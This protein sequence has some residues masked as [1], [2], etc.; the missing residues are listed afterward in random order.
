VLRAVPGSGNLRLIRAPLQTDAACI[1]ADVVKAF[2]RMA[3]PPRQAGG[4]LM[5]PEVE[6][7]V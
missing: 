7:A 6:L 1:L 4:F 5:L 3:R 2:A